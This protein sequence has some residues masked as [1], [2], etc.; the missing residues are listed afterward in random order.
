MM[1]QMITQNSSIHWPRPNE[2][3]QY[4]NHDIKK[5]S[6]MSNEHI[7]NTHHVLLNSS[8]GPL[9][10]LNMLSASYNDD[11][12]PDSDDD[13]ETSLDESGMSF[14]MSQ[15][16]SSL[17]H[18]HCKKPKNR[19]SKEEDEMLNRL[20]EQYGTTN[21]DWKL[22]ATHFHAPA[23]TEYQCQQRWQKVLNPDLIKGE[24]FYF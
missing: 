8:P 24:L 4:Y 16:Q 20:C 22:I 7:N 15:S 23:R 14:A 10:G 12:D 6:V 11:F 9:M 5:E 1:P 3:T 18:V 19:W 2:F 13:A 17:P 21:K